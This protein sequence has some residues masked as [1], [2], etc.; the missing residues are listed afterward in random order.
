[1]YQIFKLLNIPFMCVVETVWLHST[2]STAIKLSLAVIL[3]GI[4]MATVTDV[5]YN[6]VGLSHGLTAVVTTTL[7]QVLVKR[8]TGDK[9][10]S[11][12]QLTYCTALPKACILA[13][14]VPVMENDPGGLLTYQYT[15]LIVCMI[16]MTCILGI[17]AATTPAMIIQST[18]PVT[19]QVVGHAKTCLVF[20]SGFIF[21]HAP[22]IMKNVFGVLI[23]LV[24]MIWYS[25][26]KMP[27]SKPEKS[28]EQNVSTC[29]AESPLSAAPK[30][31]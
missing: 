29:D 23:A 17:V 26:L 12:L 9:G 14:F 31:V 2:F 24:G 25:Y 30:T 28:E 19:F 6:P 7:Y 15:P 3:G 10:I 5:E 4:A 20:L 18:T 8:T 1:M 22:V 21:F 11:G 13:I 27:Q 16:A